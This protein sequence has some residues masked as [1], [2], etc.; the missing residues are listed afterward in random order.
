MLANGS[1]N[2]RFN[3][4]TFILSVKRM[5]WLISGD[6]LMQIGLKWHL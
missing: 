1:V 4:K 6:E 3:D 2:V 5:G